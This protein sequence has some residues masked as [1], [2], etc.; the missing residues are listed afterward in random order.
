MNADPV[1]RELLIPDPSNTAPNGAQL[2]SLALVNLLNQLQYAVTTLWASG[3]TANRP[4]NPVLGQIYDDLTLGSL[5]YCTTVAT[6]PHS[7]NAVWTPIGGGG[8]G[9]TV[10]SITATTPIVVTPNPIT[11]TGVIS[12]A[13]S[14]V[15]AGTYGD[16]THVAQVVVEADGHVTSASSVA[17]SGL[18]FAGATWLFGDGS[19][20]A[21]TAD[22]TATPAW[23]TKSGNIYTMTRNAYLTN[24]TVNSGVTILN[25]EFQIWGTGTLTGVDATSIIQCNGTTNTGQGA[26]TDS[27]NAVY[28]SAGNANPGSGGVGQTGSPA[29]AGLPANGQALGGNGGAGGNGTGTGAAGGTN[30]AILASAGSLHGASIIWGAVTGHNLLGGTAAPT[31]TYG[32]GAG[33]GGGG[34][35]VPGHA[36]GGGGP[37]GGIVGV[38]FYQ[39]AGTGKITAIG[40]G[41]APGQG[42]DASGGGGGGGGV[43]FVITHTTNWNSLWTTDVSGGAAGAAAGTGAA[44]TQGSSGSVWPFIV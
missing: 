28:G 39:I 31:G 7:A 30:A 16:S 37:G 27:Y 9:G 21:F 15:A 40:G 5:V 33:G 44:G 14:G 3:T 34:K 19:D 10:T 8:G 32:S 6:D 36:G 20:G 42:G 22:G 1:S 11:A 2:P 43:I 17:I 24:L 12:H 26:L 25:K 23:A 29:G 38:L 13:A 4:P 35:D 41:G 18:P